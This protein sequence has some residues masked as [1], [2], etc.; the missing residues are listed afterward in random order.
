MP[1]DQDRMVE[2]RN[3]SDQVIKQHEELGLVRGKSI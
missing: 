2:T 1:G 3:G